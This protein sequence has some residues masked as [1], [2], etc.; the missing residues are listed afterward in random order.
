MV[1]R[2]AAAMSAALM[3]RWA[4]SSMKAMAL[5]DDVGVA[6]AVDGVVG[7]GPVAQRA[8]EDLAEHPDAERCHLG[9]HVHAGGDPVQLDRAAVVPS[10][11]Q[12][13]PDAGDAQPHRAEGAVEHV[14]G[15][16]E[17]R[18]FEVGGHVRRVWLGSWP[19]AAR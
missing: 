1:T 10:H 9:G 19:N 3:S 6:G 16:L 7:A 12:V 13:V 18:R 2:A 14:M 4:F 5:G 17:I 15:G 8:A 11:P